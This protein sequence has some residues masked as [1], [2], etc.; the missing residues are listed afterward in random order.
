MEPKDVISNADSP[1][2]TWEVVKIG[3]QSNL[4]H[5]KKTLHLKT[6]NNRSITPVNFICAVGK[7]NKR[8]EISC[9]YV[10]MY[11]CLG[12]IRIQ[13]AWRRSVSSSRKA[14]KRGRPYLHGAGDDRQ[15]W[16]TAKQRWWMGIPY[17]VF[18]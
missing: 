11:W 8:R 16:K 2:L 4:L 17:S 13:L 15:E 12:Q 18:F 10:I 3:S 7:F 1:K 5:G 9:T 6:P 14:T